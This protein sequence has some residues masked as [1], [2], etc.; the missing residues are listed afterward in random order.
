M[1]NLFEQMRR[2]KGKSDEKN[3]FDDIQWIFHLK[4]RPISYKA[5][6]EKLLLKKFVRTNFF[7]LFI[8]V[9]FS[10]RSFY[11]C[12]KASESMTNSM[13]LMKKIFRQIVLKNKEKKRNEVF[14][15]KVDRDRKESQNL[16][17]RLMMLNPFEFER[18]C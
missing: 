18:R 9:R 2:Y 11:L 7:R 13:N 14:I 3:F 5:T 4:T 12:G 16:N 6:N 10:F 1:E 8:N 17:F 15:F